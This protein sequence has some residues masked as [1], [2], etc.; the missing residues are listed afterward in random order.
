MIGPSDMN[1]KAALV[2]GASGDLGRA[3]ALQ[4][5]VAG[6]NVC[7]V[8]AESPGLNAC[9]DALA[10]VGSKP[11]VFATNLAS[12]GNCRAAVEAAVGAFGRLDALCNVAN[13]FAPAKSNE[14]PEEDWERTLAINLS[15]PF[16]L[17]QAALPHLIEAR[18]AIVTVTS[19]AAFMATP[20]TAA[21]SASKAGVT[22]MTRCLAKE[23]IEQPV[24]INCL[25]PGSMAV[26]SGNAAKIP[27]NVDMAKVQKLSPG[28][29]MIDVDRVAA[30]A[31]F[32]VSD[33]AAGFHGAS[34]SM[35]N[36]LSLG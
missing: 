21:Y 31:A 20:F 6:A 33:A 19:C 30:V 22:Q 12:R 13:V 35:D 23:L 27:D 26:G 9:A 16:Y 24:R 17:I 1:G 10:A 4:L 7:L 8:D 32:L 34:L 5:A 18:G 14:M 3:V 36:G 25:A 2:T 15:A 28:R 29:G 11:H